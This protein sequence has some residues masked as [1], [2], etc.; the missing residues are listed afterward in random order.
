MCASARK[1]RS[2]DLS[3]DS[4]IE[5]A[6]ELHG[7]L[8]ATKRNVHFLRPNDAITGTL[9][10]SPKPAAGDHTSGD[11]ATIETDMEDMATHL[12]E[13]EKRTKLFEEESDK[14]RD[15][16]GNHASAHLC[17]RMK[18]TYKYVETYALARMKHHARIVQEKANLLDAALDELKSTKYENE[19]LIATF[20]CVVQ[21]YFD[22][23]VVEHFCGHFRD[24]LSSM[25]PALGTPKHDFS[26]P[27]RIRGNKE[28]IFTRTPQAL[29]RQ[30]RVLDAFSRLKRN[31]EDIGQKVTN[32]KIQ[33]SSPR[34]ELKGGVPIS[35]SK[36]I[37]DLSQQLGNLLPLQEEVQQLRRELQ[38]R[39]DSFKEYQHL[40]EKEREASTSKISQLQQ[41]LQLAMRLLREQDRPDP[42][43]RINE[44]KGSFDSAV[45]ANTEEVSGSMLR[46][47]RMGSRAQI[48]VHIG[49]LIKNELE[50]CSV[51]AVEFFLKL[52][53]QLQLVGVDKKI[54]SMNSSML[55]TTNT[56]AFQRL[57]NIYLKVDDLIGSYDK[58]DGEFIEE[59]SALREGLAQVLQTTQSF[60]SKMWEKTRDKAC[61]LWMIEKAGTEVL[62]QI[63]RLRIMWR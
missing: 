50:Q 32:S 42:S 14:I 58:E 29:I 4:S 51:M 39:D 43:A 5:D 56:G 37:E 40:F 18:A 59:A 48:P 49:K 45:L 20:R 63:E 23:A 36:Q 31:I 41:D 2:F 3:L 46:R 6:Y 1:D 54:A 61:W 15:E 19:A 47:R 53:N 8:S 9:K 28:N 38:T 34:I 22:Q 12:E 27:M 21:Y 11:L 60:W 16:L 55:L 24:I 10:Y 13:V 62:S 57:M 33:V 52:K 17:E 35:T 26:S 44:I 7:L 30:Q 25:L